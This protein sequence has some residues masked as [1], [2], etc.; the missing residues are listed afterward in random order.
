MALATSADTKRYIPDGATISDADISSFLEA[1]EEWV[2]RVLGRDFGETSSPTEQFDFVQQGSIIH[3][4]NESPTS[5]TVTGF[6]FPGSTGE[7]LIEDSSWSLLPRGQIEILFYRFAGV[8][9]L[10]LAVR[11]V[12]PLTWHKITVAYTADTTVPAPI[13]EAVAMIAAAWYIDATAGDAAGGIISEK[14][15]DYSYTRES[16]GDKLPIPTRA[17]SLIRPWSK[18]LRARTT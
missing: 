10:P 4:S 18:G 3:L 17:R 1:A 9:G 12:S 7:T 14:L 11:E 8:P 13:R 2:I 6:L 5:I 15:G 16:S